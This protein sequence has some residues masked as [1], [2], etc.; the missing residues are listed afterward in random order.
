MNFIFHNKFIFLIVNFFPNNK[1]YL[2]SIL[3]LC[4][5]LLFHFSIN[6]ANFL[7]N[8]PFSFCKFLFCWLCFDDT[9][10]G[11]FK[12][13]MAGCPFG[14][15]WDGGKESKLWKEGEFGQ[16]NSPSIEYGSSSSAFIR[17]LWTFVLKCACIEWSSIKYLAQCKQ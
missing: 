6:I 13:S 15:Y 9:F 8:N 10:F 16:N 4:I 7:H 2:S 5:F 14:L 17:R 12:I 3:F 11:F 1:M